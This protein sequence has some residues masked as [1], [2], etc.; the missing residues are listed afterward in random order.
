MTGCERLTYSVG[1][2]AK[3]LGL[4]RNSV[5]QACLKGEMPC[6][7]IGKRILIPRARLDRLLTGNSE[8]DRVNQELREG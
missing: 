3:V 1:E 6:L 2:A 5:Y 7:K 4:S 8:P